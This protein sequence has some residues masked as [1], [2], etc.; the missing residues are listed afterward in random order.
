M[1]YQQLNIDRIRDKVSD[2]K[3]SLTNLRRYA[4]AQDEKFL[5]NIDAVGAARYSFIVLIEASMNIANHLCARMLDKAPANYA[6][7]FLLLGE[8]GIINSGLTEKLAQM[9]R[10]RNLLVHGYAKVDDMRMLKTIRD[11]L[12]DVDEFI[13][14]IGNIVL[15]QGEKS[16]GD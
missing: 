8:H 1:S 5:T 12:K 9:A 6:E 10:F 3:Y 14:E 13:N 15:G 16:D 2:I 11:D 4:G 7:T